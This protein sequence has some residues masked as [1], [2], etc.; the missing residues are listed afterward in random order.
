[1]SNLKNI[2]LN[3]LLFVLIM[4]SSF[5]LFINGSGASF[6]FSNCPWSVSKVGDGFCDDADTTNVPGKGQK[7]SEG[8][9]GIQ[10]FFP[11]PKTQMN[12]KKSKCN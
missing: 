12:K 8:I 2:N 7:I 11:K 6:D 5:G 10:I 1:M 4:F 3:T 9:Y